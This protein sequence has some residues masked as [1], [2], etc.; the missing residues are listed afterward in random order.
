MHDPR[1]LKDG[2]KI[3]KEGPIPDNICDSCGK[4][5]TQLVVSGSYSELVGVPLAPTDKSVKIR[6][7]ACGHLINEHDISDTMK[8]L[9]H[10]LKRGVKYPLHWYG[11]LWGLVALV[12]YVVVMYYVK[13]N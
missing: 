3:L 2:S 1:L 11:F 12:L 7:K 6:C 10:A 5:D 9:V 4:P 8:P 13:T